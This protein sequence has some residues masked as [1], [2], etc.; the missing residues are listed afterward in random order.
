MMAEREGFEP[1]VPLL[2]AHT[3]SSRAPSASSDISPDLL[4]VQ[5]E[6]KNSPGNVLNLLA[7]LWIDSPGGEGGI[8]THDPV[9][10]RI[11]LFESRA[12]SRS[13]TSPDIMGRSQYTFC[14]IL[15]T[16]IWWNSRRRDSIF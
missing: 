6:K 13:A 4:N 5:I 15:S 11:L 7:G 2:T 14:L 12:F 1:S 8:R 9:F 10:D 3:I 16:I